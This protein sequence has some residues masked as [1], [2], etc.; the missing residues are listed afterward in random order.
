MGLKSL[1]GLGTVVN[2]IAIIAAGSIGLLLKKGIKQRFQD[3]LVQA[4]GV[5]VIFIGVSGALT[6]LLEF[7]ENGKLVTKGG[8]ALI[9]SMLAGS[10]IGEAL[11]IQQ[12]LESF[13]E[14]LK[15]KFG[16]KNDSKFIEGFISAS[17]T[18]CVGAMA[19]VGAIEDGL[20]GDASMLYVKSALDFV[21]VLVFASVYGKGVVFSAIP[22]GILQGG[23]TL[24]AL[25]VSNILNEEII[26]GIS[27]TGSVLIFCVG[28][29][30]FTEKKFK[31]ANMLPS[32]VIIALIIAFTGI[33]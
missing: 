1:K 10:F 4:L 20:R 30:F 12:G 28:V 25:G 8:M 24:A 23:V 18:V 26:S 17:L 22:A 27:F 31:V 21:F 5:C 32:L 9:I 13:G 19:I 11:N 3:T 2:V 14:R 29:N 33:Y 15:A 7:S 6:G 16:G